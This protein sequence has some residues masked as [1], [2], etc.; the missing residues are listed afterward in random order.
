MKIDKKVSLFLLFGITVSIPTMTLAQSQTCPVL[1]SKEV[2]L[3][4]AETALYDIPYGFGFFPKIV[5]T[6]KPNQSFKLLDQSGELIDKECW[7]KVESPLNKEAVWAR[8]ILVQ[9][10]TPKPSVNVISQKH[11]K[12]NNSSLKSQSQPINQPT[13]KQVSKN[14]SPYLLVAVS[15][16]VIL[17]L[18]LLDRITLSLQK[19]S[20]LKLH[21][22]SKNISTQ[23]SNNINQDNI[24]KLLIDNTKNNSSPSNI[25]QQPNPSNISEQ[26]REIELGI[27]NYLRKNENASFI[28]LLS[29]LQCDKQHLRDRLLILQEEEFIEIIDKADENHTIY[30]ML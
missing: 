12:E 19:K 17:F 15:I 4:D 1:P 13:Q 14:Y 26:T 9:K 21:Q 11:K 23:D 20:A 22:K 24:P 7:Y 30:K 25:S 2:I 28:D 29:N 6:I 16:I 5:Y 18:S 27:L 10:P 8:F 3:H